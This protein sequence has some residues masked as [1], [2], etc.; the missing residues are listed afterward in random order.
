MFGK[1]LGLVCFLVVIVISCSAGTLPIINSRRC[2]VTDRQCPNVNV[3]FYLYTR[4]TQKRPVKLDTSDPKS[5]LSAKFAKDRPLVILAHGFT[6]DRDFSP[7]KQIRPAYF[8]K[9]EF[10]IVSLDYRELVLDPCYATAVANLQTVANCTAQ[11]I[12]FLL[13][14]N[15]FTLDSIHV[16]GFSLGAHTA[17]MI[18]NFMSEDRKLKRITGLDPAK[19]FFIFVDNEDRLDRTD[20]EFV[21]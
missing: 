10:N 9:D 3:S 1:K 12:N 21:E 18:A 15:L 19:P 11:L 4:E 20:A 8:K 14:E 17:G 6:G 2:F 16:I 5:I 13:D 7:N